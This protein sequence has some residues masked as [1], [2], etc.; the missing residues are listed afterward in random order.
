[1]IDTK[2]RLGILIWGILTLVAAPATG[3]EKAVPP[4]TF[5]EEL[6][7][8]NDSFDF[9]LLLQGDARGNVGPCG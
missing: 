7:A 8:G 6:L 3:Q 4:G 1:M 2:I 9:A 5:P